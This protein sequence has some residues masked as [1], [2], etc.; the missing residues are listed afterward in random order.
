MKIITR[1]LASGS[2]FIE[3]LE[4]EHIKA[5][6]PRT[7]EM[8]VKKGYKY[9]KAQRGMRKDEKVIGMTRHNYYLRDLDGTPHKVFMSMN[10]LS[11]A[12]MNQLVHRHGI[13]H[14]MRIHSKI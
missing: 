4:E 7:H 9:D 2:P 1:I 12:E 8:L 13:D 6:Y 3:G 11:D 10:S 14:D 5:L